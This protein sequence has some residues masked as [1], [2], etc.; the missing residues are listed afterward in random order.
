M[1]TLHDV[2]ANN[3]RG[4]RA[5]RRWTQEQLADRLGWPKTSIYDVERGRRRLTL[6]DLADL[7]AAFDLP[8]VELCRGA[9]R[10]R[11]QALGLTDHQG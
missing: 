3:V 9:E 10:T 2:L 1:P 5:R 7:C 11:L 6:D 8:L 4:E